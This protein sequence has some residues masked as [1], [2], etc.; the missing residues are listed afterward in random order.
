MVQIEVYFDESGTHDGAPVLCVGGYIMTKQQTVNFTNE[1][2]AE[3]ANHGLPYFHMV[4]CAHGSGVF[5]RLSKEERVA[6]E[7]E[8][9]AIIK[10]HT[11]QGLAVTVNEIEFST[12]MLQHSLIGSPYSFCAHVLLAGVSSWLV[13]NPMVTNVA[14]FFESGHK[15][16]S[17]AN[18]I[19]N[20]LFTNAGARLAHRYSRHAFVDKEKAPPVQAADLLA[21]QWY[22]DKRHQLEGR[23]R[24]KDC[25]SLTEHH[26]NAIHIGPE[27]LAALAKAMPFGAND[28]TDLMRLHEGDEHVVRRL[29]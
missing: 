24:R 10:R 3:L 13:A 19:M 7:I 26:H 27:K 29:R 16:Q 9:I 6:T 18:N 14:Y 23:P 12:Y 1:W 8:M 25:A 4:D 2:N 21:W 5:A 22:S 11:V 28:V 20:I 17:E 15:H